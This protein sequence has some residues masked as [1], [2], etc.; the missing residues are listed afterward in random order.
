MTAVPQS[1]FR[2][3]GPSNVIVVATSAEPSAQQTGSS[4][5]RYGFQ[6]R[7]N[8][9]EMPDGEYWQVGLLSASFYTPAN[10]QVFISASV[11]Q[12]S[13]VGAQVVNELFH[14]P[15]TQ[16]TAGLYQKEV[17]NIIYRPVSTSAL[18]F[19]EVTLTDQQG[20]PLPNP[21]NPQPPSS[22]GDPD[23]YITLSFRRGDTF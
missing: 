6:H 1:Q 7:V 21:P 22:G 10:Q 18:T 2:P 9:L 12:P 3:S 8:L 20:N 4:D 23:T 17:T 16:G 13:R 14:I 19:I 11:V 15:L 5:I